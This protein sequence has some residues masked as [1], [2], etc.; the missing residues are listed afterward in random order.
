[1]ETKLTDE[2]SPDRC[3]L[4]YFCLEKEYDFAEHFSS[5]L[6]FRSHHLIGRQRFQSG[7][8]EIPSLTTISIVVR[9]LICHC[10]YMFRSLFY[11]LQAEYTI[12]VFW[13]LLF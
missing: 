12:F 7:L 4:L 9:F 2:G 5:S 8:L 13:K 1:M 3:F 6:L 11:H 10:R